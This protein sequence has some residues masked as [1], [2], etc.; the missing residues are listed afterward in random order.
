M[1]AMSNHVQTDPAKA[2]ILA[3]DTSA[4]HCAAALVAGSH[5]LARYMEP[6]K[7][8]QA[9]RLIPLL[10]DTL[11]EAG[12]AWRDLDAIAVG[13]G[14]GNFTGTRIAVSAARGL[15]LGLDIPAIGV[16]TFEALAEGVP[17]PAIATVAAPRDR[18]YAQG[19]GAEPAEPILVDS[20]AL[21]CPEG[22]RLLSGPVDPVC[23]AHAARRRLGGAE[24]PPPAPL[25]IRPANAAPAADPPP[26]IFDD[27]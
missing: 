27:A 11:Q 3:F 18:I 23:L 15:A 16:T 5:V 6:M 24:G 19:F 13:I 26:L 22:T 21:Q 4:A 2:A 9:E 25:Y 1:T 10:E 14:P 8:G 20:A 7:K 12:L 17:R